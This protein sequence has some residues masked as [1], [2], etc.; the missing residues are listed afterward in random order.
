MSVEDN[1]LIDTINLFIANN[2]LR[3][4]L[5]NIINFAYASLNIT[6]ASYITVEDS[7]MYVTLHSVNKKSEFLL[8][9]RL[10]YFENIPISPIQTAVQE[11]K[12]VILYEEADI[13]L[14]TEDFNPNNRPNSIACFPFFHKE[15]VLGVLYTENVIGGKVLDKS[16]SE[17]FLGLQKSIALCICNALHVSEKKLKEIS[18][19]KE[20][21]LLERSLVDLKKEKEIALNELKKLTVIVRETDNSIMIYDS[22]WNL[23]WV[24][25]SF[26]K[27]Y[28]YTKSEFIETFGR[29][30]TTN[31]NTS[32]IKELIADCINN[33][34]SAT[35]ETHSYKRSGEKIW[36]QRTLTPIFNNKLKLDTF[37]AID[38]DITMIKQAQDE[39]N[40]QKEEIQE[41]RNLAILQRDELEEQRKQLVKA[42]KKNSQQS[43]KMQMALEKI[44]EQNSA[45]EEARTVADRANAEKS[46]FLANMSHEIRTPM[47]GI[48]GM[49]NL[50][51]KTELSKEQKEYAELVKNS[52]GSLLGIINDILDISKIESGK[53]ELDNE[54]FDFISLL[55]NISKTLQIKAKEKDIELLETIDPAIPQYI[56]SDS[57]RIKQVIINLINN[58]VKFTEEGSVTVVAEYANKT[59]TGFD[60]KISVVDTGIGISPEKLEKVFESFA[61]ADSSTT[62]KYGGTGLGLSISKQLIEILGGTIQIK[63][64]VG[65]GS[66]FWFSIPVREAQEFEIQELLANEMEINA[67]ENISFNSSFNILIAEDNL[68]NQKYISGL[69]K[70]NNIAHTIVENGK[71]ALEEAQK[72]QYSCIL[73]DMHMP[74]MNGLEATKAIRKLEDPEKSKIPIIALSAAAYKEDE[75][76]MLNAGMNYFISK[77]INEDKLLSVL[78]KLDSSDELIRSKPIL[79]SVAKKELAPVSYQQNGKFENVINY[80]EFD[81]NFSAFSKKIM[82]ELV[83]DFEKSSA[84]KLNKIEQHIRESNFKHLKFDAHSLKG[85][86]AM[87]CADSV[88][89][90]LLTLENM[91]K[92]EDISNGKIAFEKAKILVERLLKELKQKT[93]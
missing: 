17:Q 33:R 66:T 73:M 12:N 85:E 46:L 93:S 77:P 16:T 88:R 87:F 22:D 32:N 89:E 52:A 25:N 6:S 4:L 62:R 11:R 13:E 64:E 49:T 51:L 82:V 40:K 60:L 58:A 19:E 21:Q 27:L 7:D 59:A 24:N 76:K 79:H 14:N 29:N 84:E 68:T 23:E 65:K 72:S 56:Y 34:K 67:W 42:F 9:Q 39:I 83:G 71:L 35:F 31:S 50:L 86:V 30:I 48:I 78:Q 38:F 41:Q 37:V 45:L 57:L 44:N 1:K 74:E 70:M 53:I 81:S 28:G 2:D 18:K 3:S 91:G 69:L 92:N 36:I 43:V 15:K 47:N 55:N 54:C 63:S 61:Q 5:E 20:I 75:E 10:D 80:E 26:L 90:S 8:K